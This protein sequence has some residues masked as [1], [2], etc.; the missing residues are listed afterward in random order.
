MTTPV[1]TFSQI[2]A[3]VAAIQQKSSSAYAAIGI[4]A[5]GR[6]T[7]AHQQEDNGNRYL[8]Y[9]VLTYICKKPT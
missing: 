6:W 8:I 1:P 3:Q 7:G 2:K 5:Q 9:Q 4:H